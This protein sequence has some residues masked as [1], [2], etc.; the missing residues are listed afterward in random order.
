MASRMDGNEVRVLLIV[1]HAGATFIEETEGKFEVR[2]LK[3]GKYKV[4]P[5][6]PASYL[7]SYR[8]V[9]VFIEDRGTRG[10]WNRNF[11]RR[12]LKIE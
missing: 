7:P 8:S 5:E 1:A 12:V 4:E 10:Q 11:L 2:K 3:A 6:F 9:D